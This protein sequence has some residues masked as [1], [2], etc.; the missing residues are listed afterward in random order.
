MVD[1]KQIITYLDMFGTKNSFYTN[2][3]PKLYTLM[4]GVLT[5]LSFF[6]CIVIFFNLSL[7]DLIEHL[8][9]LLLLIYLMILIKNLNLAKK[10][11]G[12]HGE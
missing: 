3:K 6:I 4:G 5:L 9:L 7:D 8:Q 11:Y 10:K 2:Q 12:F 1:I